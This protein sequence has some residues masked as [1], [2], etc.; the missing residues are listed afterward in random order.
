MTHELTMGEDGILRLS[1]IGDIGPEDVDAYVEELSPFLD[2]AT[3]ENPLRILSFSGR[4]GKISAVARKTFAQLN[5]DSR[6][7]KV[8]ILGGNRF[9]R[10]MTTII[11]KA[12]GRQNIRF[13]GTE[14]E[15]M[16]WLKE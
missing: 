4:E 5:E 14:T 7:G 13:F 2:G 16:E 12:T 15:A 3:A 8:A 10:V 6:M 9:T 1:F 11:L